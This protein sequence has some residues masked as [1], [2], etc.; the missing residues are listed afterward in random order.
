[1]D[2]NGFLLGEKIKLDSIKKYDLERFFE[3]QSQPINRLYANEE[4]PFPLTEK[5]HIDF[6]E[7]ISGNKDSFIFGI[8]T[9]DKI[10]I[11]TCGIY[12]ID[13]QNGFGFVGI[14]IDQ[15]YHNQGYGTDA[16]KTLL[17]FVFEFISINK[18]KLQVFE[19]NKSAIASYEKLGFIKEG[20]MRQ[21]IFR[22]GQYFD[23]I[24]YGILREEY[25]R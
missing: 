13:W 21:E 1:M 18:I 2:I 5:D 25:N 10:L 17:T 24:Q 14:A 4:I 12:K 15:N 7:S 20:T 23:V 9:E 16:M 3:L 11:G 19:F 6:Y 8:Y 22:F